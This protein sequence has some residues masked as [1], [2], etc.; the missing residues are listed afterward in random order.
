M[1][2]EDSIVYS[3]GGWERGMV[4][5]FSFY[6]FLLVLISC[7]FIMEKKR[8]RNRKALWTSKNEVDMKMRMLLP[9]SSHGKNSMDGFKFKRGFKGMMEDESLEQ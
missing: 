1:F 6:L 8:D 7:F 9:L 4:Q 5:V 2:H 3:N